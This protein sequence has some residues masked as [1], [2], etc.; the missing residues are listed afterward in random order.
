M[1]C[2]RKHF[3]WYF[4]F[5]LSSLNLFSFS[6]FIF[7]EPQKFYRQLK[8]IEHSFHGYIKSVEK[9]TGRNWVFN[10]STGRLK[11]FKY[12]TGRYRLIKNTYRLLKNQRGCV[13]SVQISTGRNWVFNISTGRLK[14]FKFATG[15][16]RLFRYSTCR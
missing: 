16:Y 9:F 5:T 3:I 7:N 12:S 14:V 8:G 13:K 1:F 2:I 15:R 10:I 6:P 11:V 4:L